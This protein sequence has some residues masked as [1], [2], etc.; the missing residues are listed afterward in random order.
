MRFVLKI[1]RPMHMI[2]VIITLGRMKGSLKSSGLIMAIAAS[3]ICADR[4]V[5][6]IIITIIIK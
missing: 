3:E 6:M 4:A 1:S 5:K 2:R